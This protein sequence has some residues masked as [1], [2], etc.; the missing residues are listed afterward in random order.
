[1]IDGQTP[2]YVGAYSFTPGDPFEYSIGAEKV[3]DSSVLPLPTSPSTVNGD[4][5]GIPGAVVEANDAMISVFIPKD[6]VYV[7][8][9]MLQTELYAFDKLLLN[10]VECANID[11]SSDPD[12]FIANFIFPKDVTDYILTTEVVFKLYKTIDATPIILSTLDIG[13]LSVALKAGVFD[14]TLNTSETGVTIAPTPDPATAT[15]EC[16][17]NGKAF[18][19]ADPANWVTGPNTLV[20]KLSGVS[21][22]TDTTYTIT[23]NY[24]VEPVIMKKLTVDDVYG[25]H[26]V[27]IHD[28]DPGLSTGVV[29]GYEVSVTGYPSALGVDKEA[30]DEVTYILNGVT[31][32]ADDPAMSQS[33]VDG[34]PEWVAGANTL[35]LLVK[36]PAGV[37]ST[38]KYVFTINVALEKSSLK[39]L[40]LAGVNGGANFL[41]PGQY[42]YAF[43]VTTSTNLLETK[44][45]T[46]SDVDDVN[47]NG[48]VVAPG[49]GDHSVNLT[50]DN[51][52]GANTIQ[53]TVT[54]SGKAPATYLIK[55]TPDLAPSAM[56]I[57]L[58][59]DGKLIKFVNR[60]AS[61]STTK[62][63]CKFDIKLNA[64]TDEVTM[65]VNGTDYN[66]LTGAL[67]VTAEVK[68]GEKVE[69]WNVGNNVV[70]FTVVEAD[71][72]ETVYTL[73][74]NY[75]ATPLK[76]KTLTRNGVAQGL[77]TSQ[78]WTA[79][80]AMTADVIE[81]TADIGT[82]GIRVDGDT[83]VTGTRTIDWST[84][85]VGVHYIDIEVESTDYVTGT[86]HID[87]N[88]KA[89]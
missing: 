66:P 5:S 24:G 83:A 82:V 61:I 45:N 20:I 38:T 77:G 35:E 1:M 89:P 40:T 73:N 72:K 29:T 65:N 76:L 27:S 67:M 62:S 15:I 2:L 7:V 3:S 46:A 14:Y 6:N 88:V 31:K 55:I 59:A 79:T 21:G 69:K 8:N 44:V 18:D 80:T 52:I 70:K 9:K 87:V 13:S 58:E 48:T 60:N 85:S 51:L 12:Y 71:S 78:S 16:M 81:G 39:E 19:L 11:S 36:D 63:T 22:Y 49:A 53:I 17:L 86:Y 28:G 26:D 25:S 68:G 23:V 74:V 4:I 43:T 56:D 75:Q 37:R 57:Y 42:E 34:W 47:L 30:A 50:W 64:A 84:Y 32:V 41:V 10:G 54:E 33:G